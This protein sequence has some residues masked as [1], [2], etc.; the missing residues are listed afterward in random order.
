MLKI[1]DIIVHLAF[2]YI[3]EGLIVSVVQI[4]DIGGEDG[5]WIIVLI[6]RDLRLL[7]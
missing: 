3:S 6:W 4:V 2:W 5:E 7:E 1:V